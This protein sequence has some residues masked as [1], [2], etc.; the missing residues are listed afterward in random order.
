MAGVLPKVDEE[1]YNSEEE[2]EDEEEEN[3]LQQPVDG[4]DG[5][6]GDEHNQ[7]M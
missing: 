5:Q 4:D 3:Q 6:Y 7:G 1:E 2:E